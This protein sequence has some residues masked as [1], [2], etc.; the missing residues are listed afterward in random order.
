MALIIEAPNEIYSLE[1]R[2]N[3]KLFLAGSI[4]DCYDWQKQVIEQLK[5]INQLTIYNPRRLNF[6]IND[7]KAAE[8]QITWEYEHLKTAHVISFWF[9]KGSLGPITLYELGRWANCTLKKRIVIGINPEYKRKQDVEIQTRLSKPYTEFSY[10]L[11]TF[12]KNLKD[13]LH[14]ELLFKHSDPI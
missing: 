8:E 13:A 4:T 10:D 6:P 9:D 14:D 5:D 2:K 7:P 11:E 3:V 12:I 1:N